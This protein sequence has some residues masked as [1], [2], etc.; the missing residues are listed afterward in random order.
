MQHTCIIIIIFLQGYLMLLWF[1]KWSPDGSPER[2]HVLIGLVR[3]TQTDVWPINQKGSKFLLHASMLCVI[4]GP[5]ET[6]SSQLCIAAPAKE[7]WD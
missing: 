7:A 6:I 5:I 4:K 1:L 3:T 2:A